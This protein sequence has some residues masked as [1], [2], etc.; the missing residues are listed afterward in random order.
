MS[1]KII[2]AA[3]EDSDIKAINLHLLKSQHKLQK[4]IYS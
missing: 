3:E 2:E 4:V 1:K